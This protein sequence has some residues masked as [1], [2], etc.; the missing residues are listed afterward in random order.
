MWDYSKDEKNS[1]KFDQ[2]FIKDIIK[3]KKKI[4]KKKGFHDFD[5][6][7]PNCNK[8]F[9]TLAKMNYHYFYHVRI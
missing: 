7:F 8:K 2:T 5:C 4:M 3:L 1:S 6:F 9:G